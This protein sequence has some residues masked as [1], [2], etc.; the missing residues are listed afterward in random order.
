MEAWSGLHAPRQSRGGRCN[1]QPRARTPCP[2]HPPIQA[3]EAVDEEVHE[4]PPCR[5]WAVHLARR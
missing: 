5:D 1:P 4:R 2:T 3:V